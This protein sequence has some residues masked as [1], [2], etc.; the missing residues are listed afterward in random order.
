M[1][2]AILNKYRKL[3]KQKG[4]DSALADMEK[5]FEQILAT[6][7]EGYNK[8]Y[9]S[10]LSIYTKANVVGAERMAHMEGNG[11]YIVE[12]YGDIY[13]DDDNHEWFENHSAYALRAVD[14]AL[15]KAAESSGAS[16]SIERLRDHRE[17][18]LL[19]KVDTL[20]KNLQRAKPTKPEGSTESTNKKWWQFW[21]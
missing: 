21:T 17:I 12:G 13:R 20:M 9:S 1:S 15:A 14:L 4:F 8:R 2:E 3:M 5:K 16:G 19:D 7:D 11:Y 18:I 10:A 6:Y